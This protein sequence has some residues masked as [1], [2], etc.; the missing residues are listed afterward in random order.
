MPI[1]IVIAPFLGLVTAI[2]LGIVVGIVK[3]PAGAKVSV[4]LGCLVS[5]AI[6]P[7]VTCGSFIILPKLATEKGLG[8]TP[9]EANEHLWAFEVPAAATDVNYV[10]APFTAYLNLAD[11]HISEEEF[12][13]WMEAKGR[14]PVEFSTDEDGL[15]QW[16]TKDDDALYYHQ[17]DA[18]PVSSESGDLLGDPIDVQNGYRYD[19]YKE[20]DPDCGMTITYDKDNRRAYAHWHAY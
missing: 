10:Q 19:D 18:H 13:E 2:T 11:F 15:V 3:A 4:A 1:L 17:T 6:F 16:E 20:D 9:Q 8:T 12:L 14:D 7:L 5:L